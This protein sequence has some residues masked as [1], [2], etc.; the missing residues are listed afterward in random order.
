MNCFSNTGDI[1]KNKKG[2]VYLPNP[3][4][5]SIVKQRD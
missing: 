3:L 1:S 2:P 5:Y 4:A